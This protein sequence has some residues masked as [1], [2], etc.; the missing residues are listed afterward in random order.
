MGRPVS[1]AKPTQVGIRVKALRELGGIDQLALSLAVGHSKA[2]VYQIERGIIRKLSADLLLSLAQALGT[3][4]YY[5]HDGKGEPPAQ[6]KIQAAFIRF[7]QRKTPR[8][9]TKNAA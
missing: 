4:P 9:A 5:L 6:E 1:D 2:V 3:T 8:G 7:T